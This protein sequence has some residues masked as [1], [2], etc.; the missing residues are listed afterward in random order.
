MSS[1]AP[2][3]PFRTFR[4]LWQRAAFWRFC[5]M[6]AAVLTLVGVLSLHKMPDKRAA[7]PVVTAGQASYASQTTSIAVQNATATVPSAVATTATTSPAKPAS[8]TPVVRTTSLSLA[9]PGDATKPGELD[10]ALAGRTYGGS[11]RVDGYSVPL[12][13][14][15]WMI[16]SSAHY[17]SPKAMGELVFLGQVKN[18]RLAGAI[19][20]SALHVVSPPAQGFPPKL[21]G[22]YG[23]NR[24][25]LYVA[26]EAAD[27][28]GHQSCWLV[29]SL[30]TPPWRQWA[31]PVVKIDKLER[32]AAGDLAAKGVDYPQDFLR[33]RMTRT[34]TWGV[35]EVSYLFSPDA[36]GITSNDVIVASDMDWSRANI[37]R[38]P[39]KLAYVEK[40]KQW[41]G[42]FWPRF[43]A[44]F[45]TGSRQ[46]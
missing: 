41:A 30:F 26:A 21:S 44:G 8:G 33:I 23:E 24:I 13:A 39:E 18:Q 15:N 2:E 40:L 11:V 38:Y 10:A 12:P 31:D 20:I 46:Q 9:T 34:E 45:D 4:R 1:I 36:A 42:Q 19:R 28:G 37:G 22:C 7:T 17:K 5:G 43:K 35:L 27:P 25:D 29:D 14:G 3:S 32:A 6:S 16:L